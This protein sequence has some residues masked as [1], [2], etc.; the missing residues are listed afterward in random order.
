MIYTSGHPHNVGQRIVWRQTVCRAAGAGQTVGMG[1]SVAC[2][3]SSTGTGGRGA[4]VSVCPF[5]YSGQFRR[6]VVMLMTRQLRH[7]ER[8]RADSAGKT[9]PSPLSYRRI[10]EKD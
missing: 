1:L 5:I 10:Y 8:R 3:S 7:G 4:T 6:Y 9:F 2:N